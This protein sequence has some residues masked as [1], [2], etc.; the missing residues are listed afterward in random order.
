MQ[1]ENEIQNY[2][3]V[4]KTRTRSNAKTAPKVYLFPPRKLSHVTESAD[5]LVSCRRARKPGKMEVLY[6][7]H[8]LINYHNGLVECRGQ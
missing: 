6:W 7:C 5:E 8:K 3:P 2:F 1:C 4:F